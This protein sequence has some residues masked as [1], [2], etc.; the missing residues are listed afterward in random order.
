[1]FCE[2]LIASATRLASIDPFIVDDF[3]GHYRHCVSCVRVFSLVSVSPSMNFS[4]GQVDINN[5]SCIISAYF[6]ISTGFL[7][8]ECDKH[9]PLLAR[10]YSMLGYK[11]LPFLQEVFKLTRTMELDPF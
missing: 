11:L 8:A 1:M 9:M 4:V 6:I 5:K 2:T 10:F 7:A 3:L